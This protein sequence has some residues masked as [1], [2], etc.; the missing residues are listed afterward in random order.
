MF[1]KSR[2]INMKFCMLDFQ[3]WFYNNLYLFSKILKFWILE[4]DILK[5]QFS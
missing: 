1:V 3:A 5:N 2:Y 4:K